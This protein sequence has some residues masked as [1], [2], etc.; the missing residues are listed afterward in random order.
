MKLS[1]DPSVF[2]AEHMS[3]EVLPRWNPQECWF[4]KDCYSRWVPG[5]SSHHIWLIIRC[6]GRLN[7]GG[8][9]ADPVRD[10]PPPQL[11]LYLP[12]VV[13]GKMIRA[14]LDSGASDSFVSM[15]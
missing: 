1:W 2:E 5:R 9:F 3:M 14:L 12:M 6:V 15:L 7:R 13:G 10:P 4:K 8:E 11:L